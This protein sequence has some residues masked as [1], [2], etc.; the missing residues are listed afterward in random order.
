[1]NTRSPS[2]QHAVTLRIFNKADCSQAI[3]FWSEFAGLALNETLDTPEALAE[4]LQRNPDFSLVAVDEDDKIIGA[5]LCGHN[6]RAG[7]LYHLAVAET[8]RSQGIAQALVSH[9]YE[10]L[11]EANIHRCNI[12]VYGN[13]DEGN[14]FWLQNGFIDPV[15]WKVMQK[16]LDQ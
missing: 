12:F 3:A 8:Y 4:F 16:R 1:M 14:R 2:A 6:G 9:C 11:I 7:A 13:N 15:D 10:K 5:V